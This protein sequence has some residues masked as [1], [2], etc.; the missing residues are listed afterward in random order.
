MMAMKKKSSIYSHANKISKNRQAKNV[1]D[2]DDLCQ[3][4]YMAY[5]TVQFSLAAFSL[6]PF[7]AD[8]VS[9]NFLNMYHTRLV[10]AVPL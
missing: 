5:L 7:C 3:R 4:C 8:R 1:R 6:L 10:L 9:C 2:F